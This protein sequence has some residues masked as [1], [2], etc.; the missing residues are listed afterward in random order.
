MPSEDTAVTEDAFVVGDI[1]DLGGAVITYLSCEVFES[2]NPYIQPADGNC[3]IT[4]TFDVENTSDSD[5]IISSYS[6]DYYADGVSCNNCY[7]RDDDLSATLSP[8]R[9]ANGTVSFEV[10]VQSTVIEVEYLENVLTSNRV[11]F[12]CK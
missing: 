6:F 1:V 7:M 3:F 11:V 10:P 12:K 2:D 9:K 5:L 4:L 8:G